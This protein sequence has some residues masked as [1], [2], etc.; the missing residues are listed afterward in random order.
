MTAKNFPGGRR[1]HPGFPL[2]LCLVIAFG[3]GARPTPGSDG[4]QTLP[5]P[6]RSGKVSLEKTVFSRE[7]VRSFEDLSLSPESVSQLLWAAGGKTVDGITG[8]TRAYP[9]A[10][11]IYPLSFFLVAGKVD[12]IAD[13]I[14]RYRWKNHELTPVK[15]GDFRR[16]LAAAAFG[17]GFLSDAPAS[18]IITAD[19]ARTAARYGSRGENRYVSMDAGHAAQ[20]IA[21]QARALDLDTVMVGAFDDA[22]IKKLLGLEEETPL[23][24]IPVGKRKE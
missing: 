13:G 8:A 16:S 22:A 10:G 17:Q 9:S 3:C 5:P 6:D 19:I 18:I 12:G 2:C 20:N 24:V 21:L 11:G 23:Y 14:Y 4:K 7:S 15:R 1:L